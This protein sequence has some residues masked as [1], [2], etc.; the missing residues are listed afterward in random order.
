MH[1][2]VQVK[3]KEALLVKA[4]QDLAKVRDA[5]THPNIQASAQWTSPISMHEH[6]LK[7]LPDYSQAKTDASEIAARDRDQYAM[8]HSLRRTRS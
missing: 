2:L 1:C 6:T 4:T 3:D 8:R 7:I 5:L